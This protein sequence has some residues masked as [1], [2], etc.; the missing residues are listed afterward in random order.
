ME[1]VSDKN[2]YHQ[3]KF[4][5]SNITLLVCPVEGD[6]PVSLETRNCNMSVTA[7]KKTNSTLYLCPKYD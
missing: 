7:L 5:E 2:F 1:E 6:A 3:L 4:W